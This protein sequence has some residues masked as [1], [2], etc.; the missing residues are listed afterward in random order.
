MRLQVRVPEAETIH[1][2]RPEV[3]DQDVG[4]VQ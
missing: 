4:I 2:T 1:S 3:L